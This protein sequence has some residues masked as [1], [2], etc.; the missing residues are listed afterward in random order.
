VQPGLDSRNGLTFG[1]AN[2][3]GSQR[4][5]RTA[6]SYN[7]FFGIQY[8]LSNNWV[9]EANYVGS[10][11]HRLYGAVDVNRFNGD[12]IQHNGVLTRLNSSF[13]SIGY[14]QPQFTSFYTGGN[15]SIKS[16]TS[17]GLTLMAAY[18]FGKAIDMLSST[19]G[20]GV[21][22]TNLRRE[23]GL[24]NFDVRQK[25]AV[26]LMWE[27]PQPHFRSTALNKLLGGWQIANVTILQGGTPFSIGCSL[28][29][30]AVR[31]AGGAIVGNSGCD[32]NADGTTND[33]P[34]TPSFGNFKSGSRS[35]FIKGI[36]TASDFP[37]PLLGQIGNLGRNTFIGPGFA[38]TDFSIM[39]NT[40]IPWPV[41]QEGANLQFRCEFFNV[42]NRVNLAGVVSDLSNP[43]FGKST[44]TYPAR[45][46]QF[47]L[48][49][50]F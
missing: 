20:M 37:A 19:T 34:D 27:L 45:N 28:P 3:Q 38:N 32:Y 39:K 50:S 10:S 30:T 43:L 26:S 41:G 6:Y 14:I 35:D 44:S 46:I 22:V 48:R 21:D 33:R 1:K 18:T 31:D 12:M 9:V 11:G 42:F 5:F 8:A 16:R 47:G 7:W 36:F 13:G 4:D 29:F 15:A 40:K 17:H 24:A 25:L 23:R 2:I 49:L